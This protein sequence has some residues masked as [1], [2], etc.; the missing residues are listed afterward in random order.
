MYHLSMWCALKFLSYQ[1][2]L[3]VMCSGTI[4][5]PSRCN[6]FDAH[7]Q[8]SVLE[9][10]PVFRV[11]VRFKWDVLNSM[12]KFLAPLVYALQLLQL[13]C[14]NFMDFLLKFC[15]MIDAMIA[16]KNTLV[17]VWCSAGCHRSV[18]FA[19]PLAQDGVYPWLRLW[20]TS[21]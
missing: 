10:F 13:S 20:L 19:C 17:L 15:L 9:S 5:K 8:E 7:C 16:V 14:A 6:G 18:K 21:E 3:H 2:S 4:K 11:G 1:N 12:Y